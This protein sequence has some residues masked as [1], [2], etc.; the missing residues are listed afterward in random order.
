MGT[1]DDNSETTTV[2]NI[3]TTLIT[4]QVT[5]SP[6]TDNVNNITTANT[7]FHEPPLAS[8]TDGL[9]TTAASATTAKIDR[10]ND[11]GLQVGSFPFYMVIGTVSSITVVILTAIVILIIY[12]TFHMR[13]KTFSPP[14]DRIPRQRQQRINN[15]NLEEAVQSS[16]VSILPNAGL[17]SEEDSPLGLPVLLPLNDSK[18]NSPLR[19][20]SP[21]LTPLSEDHTTCT[22]S[23]PPRKCD[24]IPI[25][26]FLGPKES[27]PPF[28]KSPVKCKQNLAYLHLGPEESSTA[29]PLQL[30][31]IIC[32]QNAA[33]I[34]L[35]PEGTFSL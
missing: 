8:E 19:L 13:N 7:N 10:I 22:R 33:C 18:V 26:I 5:E 28:P 1:V 23:L 12:V 3:M 25:Y 31:P 20:I 21:A 30:K 16:D 32:K 35:D 27:D 29:T 15:S 14:S 9:I 11:H 2:H 34:H 17:D 6:T 24:Q 4:T